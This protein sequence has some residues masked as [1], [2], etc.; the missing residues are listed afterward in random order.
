MDPG[1]RARWTAALRSGGYE[2]GRGALRVSDEFCCLG[3]LCDLA[4]S[5]GVVKAAENDYGYWHYGGETGRLPRAVFGW[6]DLDG[7]S[8]EVM[9]PHLTALVELAT[10]NDDLRWD[11]AAI[12]D[13]IDGIAP[14]AE[15]T[16]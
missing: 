15:V 1:I 7:S 6:A 9:I 12:A 2:Q 16:P 13:V 3:V 11:F 5:S 4:V 8:P 10:L 14:P